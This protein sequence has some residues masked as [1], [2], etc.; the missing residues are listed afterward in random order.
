MTRLCQAYNAINLAQG[1]PDFDPPDRVKSAASRAIRQ[2]Y[3][4]YSTTHGVPRLRQAIAHKMSTYN[5][6]PCNA[7][8]NVTVTCGTTEGMIASLLALLNPGEE[9]VIFEPF[10]ENYGPDSILSGAKCK[11]VPLEEPGFKIEEEKLKEAFSRK[12]KAVIINTPHNPT[13]R[14]F[15]RHELELIRDL[16]M[17]YDAFAI[18]DEI[19][20][21]ILYDDRKHISIASL[22]GMDN[23]TITISGF[24]KTYS[25]TG[26]RV[27]YVI[28]PK[29]LTLAVRKV[30]DFLTVCAPTPLQEACITA[31][32]LPLSYYRDLRTLYDKSRKLL[33]QTL[34]NASFIC[35]I[36]EGAYYVWTDITRTGFKDDRKLAEH[37]IKKIGVGAVPGSSFYHL[38]SKGRLKLRFSF[39]KMPHTIEMAASRLSKFKRANQRS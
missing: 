38:P 2:G 24:S 27:G 30:H 12:T 16:S 5:H 31:L 34:E 22:D 10:Y 36:P 28:A 32:K 39:S 19:Y 29:K 7:D 14:V 25:A 4:Q 37:L 23:R 17:D 13:G 9:V 1:F 18:T 3:N 21:H 33:L 26:W 6:V 15:T 8:D 20:E 11:Y 35:T